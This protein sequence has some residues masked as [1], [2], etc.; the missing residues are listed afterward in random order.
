MESGLPR[1]EGKRDHVTRT[2]Q[3]S[4]PGTRMWGPESRK[5]HSKLQLHE[6]QVAS[7][8]GRHL[9]MELRRGR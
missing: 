5:V 3:K 6:L 9:E 7:N 1:S 4:L 8:V 2:E